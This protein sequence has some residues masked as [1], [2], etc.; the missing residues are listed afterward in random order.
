MYVFSF[1]S[2]GILFAMGN[3]LLDISA[4]CDEEFLKKWVKRGDDES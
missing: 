2:E 1:N 4:E 3:P